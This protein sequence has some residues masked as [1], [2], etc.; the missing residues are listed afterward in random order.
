MSPQQN[1]TI[2]VVIPLHNAE[3]SIAR[4]LD[5]VLTQQSPPL[6]ILVIDDGSTDTSPQQVNDLNHPTVRLI[7][8]DNQGV[9]IARNTGIAHAHGDIVAFLDSDDTWHPHYLDTIADLY[10]SHPDCSVYATGY[11]IEDAQSHQKIP[12]IKHIP[13]A[14]LSGELTHYFSVAAH[15][16]PPLWTSAVAVKRSALETI[17]GFPVGIHAGEDLLTWARLA[18]QFRI[19]Y[20]REAHATY[21]VPHFNQRNKHFYSDDSDPVGH[22]LL[23]LLPNIPDPQQADFHKYLGLWFKIRAGH[24]IHAGHRKTARRMTQKALSHRPYSWKLYAYWCATLLPTPLFHFAQRS[25]DTLHGIL[26][27]GRAQV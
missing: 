20:H 2:S 18:A 14:G 25:Y 23:Q 6:E 26:K 19:A 16:Y 9:S 4:T 12:T 27:P 11:V 13:F 24:L 10:R 21:R 15:S 5:S 3:H 22:A 1:P 8:Q 7:R 17:G